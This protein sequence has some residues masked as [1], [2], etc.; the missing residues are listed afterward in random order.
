M[1]N[2][3]YTKEIEALHKHNLKILL[4]NLNLLE[5]FEAQKIRC[6]FCKDIIKKNNFGAIFSQEGKIFFSCSRLEKLQRKIN[7]GKSLIP[8]IPNK[9]ARGKI[10]KKWGLIIN[11]E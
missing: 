7:A 2:I 11:A 4:K 3:K 9:K 10:N 6:H 8:Y 1:K 5:D